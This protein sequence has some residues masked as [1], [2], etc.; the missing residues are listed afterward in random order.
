MMRQHNNQHGPQTHPEVLRIHVQLVTVQF[1]QLSKGAFEV[2]QV[3]QTLTEG[4]QHLL[5]MSL[6]LRI[7]H[8]SM[9]RGQVP[10]GLE[11]PL[12]PWVDNQQPEKMK[13]GLTTNFFHIHLAPQGSD[14]RLLLTG[15]MHHSVC[16]GGLQVNTVVSKASVSSSCPALPFMP[17]S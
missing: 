17:K 4:S 12:G 10:K 5:A 16:F 1:T 8:N 14:R 7:A 13:T 15:Q 9:C 2:V 3:I 6:H 11:E